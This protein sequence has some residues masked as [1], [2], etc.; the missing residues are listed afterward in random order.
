MN[1]EWLGPFWAVANRHNRVLL[2]FSSA[3]F[4]VFALAVL[5]S[6]DRSVVPLLALLIAAMLSGFVLGR[7]RPN[8]WSYLGLVG[9]LL[10]VA[11]AMDVHAGS[12]A[13]SAAFGPLIGYSF[14]FYALAVFRRG[15][16][17]SGD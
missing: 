15:S 8:A 3:G 4:T 5:W 17:Q 1:P 12:P 16:R 10:S 7:F 9:A 14:W 13:A 6:Q 11:V 2:H